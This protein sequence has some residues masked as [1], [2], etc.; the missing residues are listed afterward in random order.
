MSLAKKAVLGTTGAAL[1]GYAVYYGLQ[2]SEISRHEAEV[3]TWSQHVAAEHKAISQSAKQIEEQEA[4]M[5]QVCMLV[6]PC[7]SLFRTWWL[8]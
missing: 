2:Y 1:S 8:C 6:C 5:K 7:W 3:A 4:R